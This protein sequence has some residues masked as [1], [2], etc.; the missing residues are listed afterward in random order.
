[1]MNRR[2]IRPARVLLLILPVIIGVSAVKAY[3][4]D[5]QGPRQAMVAQAIYPCVN[6]PRPLYIPSI[7]EGA[8]YNSYPSHDLL[9]QV[10]QG[11][12]EER[13]GPS[14]WLI[15]L[16]VFLG[17][18]ALNLT[19]CV[20][21]LIP[22]TISYFGGKSE[23]IRGHTIVHG[24]VYI[25]GLAMTNSLLGLSAALSGGML[26][27]A[28]QNPFV[29]IFVAAVMVFMGLSFFGLWEIRL[30]AWL[31]RVASKGYAGFFGTFFMGLTLGI[32]AAP[33]LGPFILGLL[34]W[35]G[36][37]GDPLLG[38]LFFFVLSVGLGL[39]LSVLAIFSG[40][41][42]RLPKSGDWML[43]VRRLMGWILIGMA[44][45]M[46]SPVV[47]HLIGRH[48]LLLG[49]SVAAGMHLGWLDK[50]GSNLRIFPYLKKAVAVAMVCGGIISL[51]VAMQQPSGIRWIPY[52]QSA[53]ASAAEQGKPVMI[54]FYA[55]W[56]APCVVMEKEIFT[57]PEVIR[58]S[59]DVIAMRVDLTREKP[60]HGELLEKYQVRG[61]PTLVFLNREGVEEEG[62]RI[63]YLVTKPEVLDR[64]RRLH[65]G[66]P[67]TRD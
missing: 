50:T 63:K 54:D 20:Y 8:T 29:L 59:R 30:P 37:M 49:V 7:E 3:T 19:P 57:D 28:L 52:D 13:R 17:G 60:F 67:P 18:L 42:A 62:L 32:I 34:L 43:W 15:L 11:S 33:C 38:F 36:Q 9:L 1:M 66:S 40:A 53:I 64:L 6:A 56:C 61:I 65:E 12:Q 48:W 22:I 41:I 25:F 14:I 35:V 21:P 24:I 10:E 47:C 51:L 58:L 44:V 2:W 46:V 23:R 5:S 4:T 45:Y 27:F 26:G 55:E 16:G 31:T 39:P